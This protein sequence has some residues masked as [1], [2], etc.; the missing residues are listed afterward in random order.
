KQQIRISR[1]LLDHV[2]GRI[3]R[4]SGRQVLPCLAAIGRSEQPR[5]A[6]VTAM[7]IERDVRCVGVRRRRDYATHPRPPGH[8]GD[9]R[10]DLG[11]GSAVVPR[12]P[13]ISV[14]GAGPYRSL[15]NRRF[16]YGE[17]RRVA[18]R[19]CLVRSEAA[20]SDSVFRWVVFGQILAD[21]LPRHALVG[22]LEQI[23]GSVVQNVGV[24]RREYVR[25]RPVEAK[26]R[27]WIARLYSWS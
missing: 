9:V 26:T 25:R 15:R 7:A 6:V 19:T 27:E 11:P 16:G 24:V 5:S 13:D 4:E 17:D 10:V 14:V 22:R 23:V 18:F 1:I 12:Q 21:R 3:L 20:S 8:V 2:Y